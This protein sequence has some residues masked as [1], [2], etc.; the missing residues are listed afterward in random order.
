M[1]RSGYVPR[2]DFQLE[3]TH[4]KK[5]PAVAAWRFQAGADQADYVMLRY[6]PLEDSAMRFSRG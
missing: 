1:R 4:K 3:L 6:V 2:A 5:R